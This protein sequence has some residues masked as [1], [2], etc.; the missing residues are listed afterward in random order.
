MIK[1]DTM[2]KYTADRAPELAPFHFFRKAT[3]APRLTLA[4]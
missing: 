4:A 2:E 3:P 1:N